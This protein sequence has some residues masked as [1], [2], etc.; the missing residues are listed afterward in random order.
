MDEEGLA[1]LK[2]SKEKGDHW[3]LN[4]DSFEDKIINLIYN[5]D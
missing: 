2:N 4:L 3:E 1:Q 5:F